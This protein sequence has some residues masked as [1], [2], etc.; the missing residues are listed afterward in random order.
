MTVS[1]DAEPPWKAAAAL[2]PVFA[3]SGSVASTS[4]S[5][6]DAEADTV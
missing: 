6:P 4:S 1:A 2:P 5:E 3:R